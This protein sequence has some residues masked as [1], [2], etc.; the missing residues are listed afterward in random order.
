MEFLIDNNEE[1]RCLGLEA[2]K[3]IISSWNATVAA[4]RFIKLSAKLF[5]S[6]GKEILYETGPC[7][8]HH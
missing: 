2:Y 7:S 8:P 4:D 5:D 1:R 3:T 6:R